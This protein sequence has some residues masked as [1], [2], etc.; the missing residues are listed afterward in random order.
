MNGGEKS[1]LALNIRA[2][3]NTVGCALSE[4][5]LPELDRPSPKTD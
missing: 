1:K 3:C 4:Y 2:M 5:Q